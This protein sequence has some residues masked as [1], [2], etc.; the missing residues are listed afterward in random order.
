MYTLTGGPH[1]QLLIEAQLELFL[2]TQLLLQAGPFP[3]VA[4]NQT[5]TRRKR[6]AEQALTL[7]VVQ[8]QSQLLA[9][10]RLLR[11]PLLQLLLLLQQL[12]HLLVVAE[13]FPH[14]LR[15][16]QPGM[17]QLSGGRGETK[18]RGVIK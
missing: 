14:Q 1:L 13:G 7:S 2:L 3:R 17:L 4:V 9:G 8:F 11:Q 15:L 6:R 16:G 5:W 10:L 12:A 18:S